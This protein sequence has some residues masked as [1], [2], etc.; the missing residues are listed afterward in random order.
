MRYPYTD[1]KLI[2]IN[3]IS[4]VEIM[5]NDVVITLDSG[6][7]LSV[8]SSYDSSDREDV[9]RVLKKEIRCGEI[10]IDLRELQNHM[11]F[12]HGVES[13]TWFS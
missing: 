8:Y 13:G 5:E 1:K 11:K 7:K 3:N 10:D 9:F 2:C 12:Y 4:L 6:R